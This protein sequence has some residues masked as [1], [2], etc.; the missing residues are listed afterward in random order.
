MSEAKQTH[1]DLYFIPY[2]WSLYCR[3][4]SFIMKVI[5]LCI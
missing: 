4:S 5:F 3:I 2:S 1:A